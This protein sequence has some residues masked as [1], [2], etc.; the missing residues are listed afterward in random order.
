[1]AIPDSPVDQKISIQRAEQFFALSLDLLCVAGYDGHFKFLNSIWSHT[2]GFSPQ[3]LLSQPYLSFVHSDDQARTRLEAER[4]T[5]GARTIR[6]ENRYR[7]KDGSYKWLL[8]NA[9]AAPHEELIYATARD[10]TEQKRKE[11]R[12]AAQ[13]AVARLLSETSPEQAVPKLLQAIGDTVG[14]GLGV[15]WTIDRKADLLRCDGIWSSSSV[16]VPEFERVT[17]VM[18]FPPGVGLPGRVWASGTPAWIPDTVRDKN[19]PR[20][21]FAAS[22]GLHGAFGFP[23]IFAG[24]VTG[25]IEFFSRE[26]E[27]VDDDLLNMIGVLG[28]QIGQFLACKRAED[29]REKV[30][31]ELREVLANVKTLSGLLP[32]CSSC[33]KIRDDKGYWNR[34]ED[35]ILAHSE[36]HITHGL[37]TDCARKMH[38]DWDQVP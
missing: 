31:L 22:T 36:A 26:V 35:Y 15:M 25:V 23:V 30:I 18:T 37:C 8:W 4:L 10:I 7:C 28:L 3:E 11:R 33:K 27:N 2:L 13:Y 32:I 34:L 38:P 5:A 21:P 12:L 16:H 9:I 6:F 1:M 20:M 24:E 17:G 29:E 14:W 19:F